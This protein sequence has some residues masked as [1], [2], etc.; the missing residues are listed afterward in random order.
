MTDLL[1][2]TALAWLERGDWNEVAAASRG[3]DYNAR[4]EHAQRMLAKHLSERADLHW[5]SRRERR[6]K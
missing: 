6:E 2:L 1:H 3:R 4:I 5:K